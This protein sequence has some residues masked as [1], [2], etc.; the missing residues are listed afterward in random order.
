MLALVGCLAHAYYK[1]CEWIQFYAK[2]GGFIYPG[3]DRPIL[4]ILFEY[5]LYCQERTTDKLVES[6]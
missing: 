6:D 3:S 5:K 4:G 2:Q 1:Q